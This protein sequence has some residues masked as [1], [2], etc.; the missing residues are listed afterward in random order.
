MPGAKKLLLTDQQNHFLRGNF[1]NE[2]LHDKQGSEGDLQTWNPLLAD[3]ILGEFICRPCIFVIA[4]RLRIT[5]DQPQW[6]TL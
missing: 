1:T 5:F 6:D 4:T 2:Y 3:G